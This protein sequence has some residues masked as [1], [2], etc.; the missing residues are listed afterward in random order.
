MHIAQRALILAF[1][2]IPV[3][4]GIASGGTEE[5]SASCKVCAG[6]FCTSTSGDGFYRCAWGPG[7]QC[8]GVDPCIAF[9]GDELAQIP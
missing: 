1:L 3:Y 8:Y 2:A 4:L 7:N 9:S 5:A 6:S